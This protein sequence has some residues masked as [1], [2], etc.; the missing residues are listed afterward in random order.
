[1]NKNTRTS[2]AGN[3]C[4]FALLFVLG[5]SLLLTPG[6]AAAQGMAFDPAQLKTL[7]P[8]TDPGIPAGTRIDSS[9]WKQYERYVPIGM[10]AMWS[11]KLFWK[12]Q[13]DFYIEV[14]PTIPEPLPD[15][16][17]ADT[18]KYSGQ[19]KLVPYPKTGGYTI[20][21]YVA[22]LPFPDPS[23]PDVGYKLLYDY[24]FS[25]APYQLFVPYGTLLV[26]RYFNRA[27][28]SSNVIQLRHCAVSD[29]GVPTNR[30]TCST[31]AF[32]TSF[33]SV[34]APEQSKYT[35]E[36]VMFPFDPGGPAEI[37]VFLPS[38]RRSLRLSASA[39]CSP[40]LGTDWT[41]DD[42]RAGL[43][44]IPVQFQVD[45]YGKRKILSLQHG[46]YKQRFKLDNYT[47]IGPGFAFPKPIVGKWELRDVYVVDMHPV[48][49]LAPTYCY[50]HRIMYLDADLMEADIGDLYDKAGKL[51]KVEYNYRT[52]VPVPAAGIGRDMM[53]LP[54]ADLIATVYDI[55]N[56]HMTFAWTT[57][58]P[59]INAEMPSAFSDPVAFGT[60][61]GLSQVLK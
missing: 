50:A 12:I 14:G 11:N 15:K 5:F 24:Y 27:D 17:R 34:T 21:G 45:Y 10:R 56:N 8:A 26:D 31:G 39:R 53:V 13:P 51:W 16:Y 61:G 52:A 29:A 23:G 58:V 2:S 33:F 1:M 6:H 60:P 55:Q 47:P 32:L 19:A 59:K 18:E 7:A 36:L 28:Q 25:Y 4:I 37:Y 54:S 43:S 3:R 48:P 46:D 22:G 42:V 40:I 57:A 20:S 30:P 49:S 38:L 35:S 9:N 44:V 41:N